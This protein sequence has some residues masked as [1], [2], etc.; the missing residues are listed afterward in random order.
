[1]YEFSTPMP[2]SKEA[3][4]KLVSINKEIEK[5][6]ITSLYFSLPST[7]ELFTG[8]EQTRNRLLNKT[9]FDFW[10]NLASYCIDNN[11]D[12]IYCLNM[13]RPLAIENPK[14]NKQIEN[15]HKLLEEFTQI[16]VKNLRVAPPKLMSYLHK[17]FPQ[18]DIYG[19]TASDYKIIQEFQFLKQVHP[20]LKQIVPSHNVNKNFMLLKNIQ[21]L[22]FEVEIMVNEGCL[23]GCSNRFEHECTFT[24]G[25]FEN[26]TEEKLFQE[27]FCRYNC[28]IIE[29][30]NPILHLVKGNHIYPWEIEEYAKTGITHFKLNGRDGMQEEEN[31]Q[32]NLTN[33]TE[34]YLKG[35]D[36]IKNIEDVPVINFVSNSVLKYKL[37]ELTVKE[38]KKYLPNI[39]H[40]VKQGQR[41]SS[42]CGAECRYCYKCTDKIQKIFQKTEEEE[43]KR[44][45]PICII[46]KI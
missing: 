9:S 3:I 25:N 39:K 31:S 11:F 32:T 29:H 41:C 42:I 34:L 44:I 17:Y 23:Q 13:P 26:H 46:S 33:M 16:G 2:Y 36:N 35:V 18:F 28:T 6:R 10:R 20:Y 1:M 38:I 37:R 7:N 43:Q 22:G 14:F 5:S 40:F 19:S 24:D 30:G 8:F 12:I 27:N 4:D 15:L 45:M 21:K